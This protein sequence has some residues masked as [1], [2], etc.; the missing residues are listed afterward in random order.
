MKILVKIIPPN[1]FL[2]FSF[3]L[4]LVIIK[5]RVLRSHFR[6]SVDSIYILIYSHFLQRLGL[7]ILKGW[8]KSGTISTINIIW[9]LVSQSFTRTV[10][11]HYFAILYLLC[12]ISNRILCLPYFSIIIIDK[13]A[14]SGMPILEGNSWMSVNKKC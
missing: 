3:F 11:L 13:E 10:L 2:S 6:V 9:N 7:T 1:H 14:P 5:K 4:N 12:G 8:Q